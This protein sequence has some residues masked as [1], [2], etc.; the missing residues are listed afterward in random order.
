MGPMRPMRLMSCLEVSGSAYEVGRR[1]GEKLAPLIRY[2]YQTA[3][4]RHVRQQETPDREEL[5]R[6]VAER[7]PEQLEEVRGYSDGAGIDFN[8]AFD[9]NF[10]RFAKSSPSCS[11]LA[12]RESPNGPILGGTL[13]DTHVYCVQLTRRAGA[14]AHVGIVYPGWLSYYGGVNEHGLA[15][16][17]SSAVLH[18][19]SPPQTEEQPM[20]WSIYTARLVLETCRSVTEAVDLL[21]QPGIPGHGNHIMIDADGN[22]ALVESNK[23]TGPVLATHA[24]DDDGRLWCGNFFRSEFSINEASAFPGLER[25]S[26]RARAVLRFAEKGRQEGGSIDLLKAM[27]TSHD[28][29]QPSLSGICNP[30]TCCAVISVPRERRILVAER[31]PC[32]NEFVEYGL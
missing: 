29:E 11:N 17:G 15:V 22:G 28:S 6:A 31:Y 16:S 8:Y 9:F 25:E 13:D 24:W 23:P 14:C 32:A 12:F 4:P 10:G 3:L 1:H 19:S 18:K 27:L 30:N 5:I 20:F 21:K 7:W 26:S 2:C